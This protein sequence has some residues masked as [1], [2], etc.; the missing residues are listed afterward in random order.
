MSTTTTRMLPATPRELEAA[1]HAALA[2]FTTAAHAGDTNAMQAA[3]ARRDEL[4]TQLIP[5]R[6]AEAAA[7]LAAL[8]EQIQ[9]AQANV[10]NVGTAAEEMDAARR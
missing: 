3:R 4:D 9:T 5:A 1:R 10:A 7:A 2:D 8:D 6:I